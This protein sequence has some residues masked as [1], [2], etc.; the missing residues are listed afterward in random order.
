MRTEGRNG[1]VNHGPVPIDSSRQKG[2]VLVLGR[3]DDAEPFEGLEVAC[4][5][6]GHSGTAA[7]EGGVGYGELLQLRDPGDARILDAPELFREFAGQRGHGGLRVDPPAVDAVGGARGAEMREAA[8]VFYAT[9]EQ[10]VAVREQRDAGV[11][12]AVDWIGP[13]LAAEDGIAGMAGKEG[14]IYVSSLIA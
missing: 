5:G 10:G 3:H 11:K 4:E 2:G 12:D 13:V 1:A 6:Q 14:Y 9:E 7:R 8:P